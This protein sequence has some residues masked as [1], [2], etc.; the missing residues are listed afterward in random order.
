[1]AKKWQERTKESRGTVS[2]QGREKRTN[3]DDF[4]AMKRR[5]HSRDMAFA[6]Q[7][8]RNS[9]SHSTG[10]WS[11]AKPLDAMSHRSGYFPSL[12]YVELFR[13]L[14]NKSF[15]IDKALITGE[16]MIKC[17][18]NTSE[19]KMHSVVYLID[20]FTARAT[21]AIRGSL[22]RSSSWFTMKL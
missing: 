20:I 12:Y 19:G 16:C 11:G 9:L 8:L 2:G 1:M 10:L 14:P 22:S 18:A 13:K 7:I 5:R 21:V 4:G 15:S 6:A 3:C 17:R